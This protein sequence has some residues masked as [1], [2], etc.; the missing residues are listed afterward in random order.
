MLTIPPA[1]KLWYCATPVDALGKRVRGNTSNNA[2]RH[3]RINPAAGTCA[4]LSLPVA[5]K[6]S[7]SRAMA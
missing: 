3:C 1:V 2:H 4:A 6:N 5:L 7:P